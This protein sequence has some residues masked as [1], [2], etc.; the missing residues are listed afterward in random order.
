MEEMVEFTE[1]V[2]MFRKVRT[3][4][5]PAKVTCAGTP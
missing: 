3:G 5:I 2:R 4:K 1:L